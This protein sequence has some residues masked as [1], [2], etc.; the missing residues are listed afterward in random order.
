MSVL[1]SQRLHINILEVKAAT[2]ILG[3][4]VCEG[5]LKFIGMFV[6]EGNLQGTQMLKLLKRRADL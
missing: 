2:K 1:S 3:M 5:N 4:F 6:F